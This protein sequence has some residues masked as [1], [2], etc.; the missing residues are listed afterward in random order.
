MQNISRRA[1]SSPN[2]LQS[3]TFHA[4]VLQGKAM[5]CTCI[6]I[7]QLISLCRCRR[8]FLTLPNISTGVALD[9]KTTEIRTLHSVMSRLHAFCVHSL[10][11]CF[12]NSVCVFIEFLSLQVKFSN[13]SYSVLTFLNVKHKSTS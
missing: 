3:V 7:G 1:S 4:V 8:G 5:K 13:F 10:S 12:F 2:T 11:I 9:V 6:A